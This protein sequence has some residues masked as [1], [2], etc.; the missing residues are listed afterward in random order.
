MQSCC[1]IRQVRKKQEKKENFWMRVKNWFSNHCCFVLLALSLVTLIIIVVFLLTQKRPLVISV[2]QFS[3]GSGFYDN[4]IEVELNA[5]N[6]RENIIYT[7]DTE[8]I[9]K[10]G[11]KYEGSI[12]LVVPEEGYKLYTLMAAYC[13]EDVKC[14][15]TVT[16]TYV[17]GKNVYE[18]VDLDI[19]NIISQE[20][21]L[22]D[23]EK[24]ILVTGKTFD[25]NAKDEESD[26][27]NGNYNQRGDEWIRDARIV[28]ID[29]SGSEKINK[30]LGLQVA[31]GTSSALAVKSLKLVGNKKYGY[32]KISFDFGDGPKLYNSLRLRSGAQDQYFGNIRSSVTSRLA[33]ESGFDGSTE[34]KRV[35][36]FLNNEFYGIFDAQQTYSDSFLADYFDLPD[37]NLV[38][39]YKES[40]SGVL[41]E[42]GIDKLFRQNLNMV[43]NREALESVVDMDNY[44][45]YFALEIMWNNTDWPQNNFEMWRYENNGDE[46]YNEYGDGRYRFLI[47]DT[48]LTWYID[49][50]EDYYPGAIGDIFEY[51]MENTYRGG[52]SLFRYVMASD[53]YQDKFIGILR[54]LMNGPFETGHILNIVDEE[55]AKIDRQMRIFYT[56]EEYAS[57]QGWINLLKKAV[58]KRNSVVRDDVKKYF[59]VA[60]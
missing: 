29:K 14:G 4:D 25:E 21:N 9:E 37:S 60:L 54:N 10:T 3:K 18:D 22:Y 43:E 2:V 51:L 7:L 35:V 46:S 38:M 32:D 50:N 28:M 36:V 30:A 12:K 52:G 27:I 33:K 59:G 40:E 58:S 8:G 34:T 45:M 16:K 23:Y 44:L 15:K 19:I 42:V 17:L 20:E 41:Q 57:W 39:K 49:G 5:D 1:I 48:D 47:Y 6:G 53:Y 26:Y 31:G 55:A 11:E 56:D 24:G 13:L